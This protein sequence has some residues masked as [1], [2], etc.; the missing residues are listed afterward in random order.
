MFV[1]L[2]RKRPWHALAICREGTDEVVSCACRKRNTCAANGQSQDSECERTFRRQGDLTSSVDLTEARCRHSPGLPRAP[3][4]RFIKCGRL[5]RFKAQLCL[6]SW[7]LFDQTNDSTCNM[8]TWQ[9][10]FPFIF[11]IGTS[12]FSRVNLHKLN[13]VYGESVSL[14]CTCNDK[15]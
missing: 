13:L 14:T 5:S 15:K 12:C 4:S 9:D 7:E 1:E 6:Y 11:S 2:Q 10:I 3:L 8:K